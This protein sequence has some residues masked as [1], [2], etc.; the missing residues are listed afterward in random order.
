MRK[1]LSQ[2]QKSMSKINL[3]GPIV[4]SLN[5]ENLQQNNVK[6]LLL[7]EEARNNCYCLLTE[8]KICNRILEVSS[9]KEILTENLLKF[10]YF[11]GTR[12]VGSNVI[13]SALVALGRM[14]KYNENYTP[15]SLKEHAA[16]IYHNGILLFNYL[17][18]RGKKGKSMSNDLFDGP[19]PYV[20]WAA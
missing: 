15:E 6:F 20:E 14:D 4:R 12:F 19:E 18:S 11:D 13:S 10:E 3:K 1:K 16:L 2:E 7:Q 5:N 8:G 17:M 9:E